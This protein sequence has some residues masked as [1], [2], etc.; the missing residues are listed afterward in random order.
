MAEPRV[1]RSEERAEPELEPRQ[2]GTAKE[3]EPELEPD[4]RYCEME[5]SSQDGLVST[6]EKYEKRR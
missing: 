4:L 2:Q 6:K 1:Y 5:D 3:L